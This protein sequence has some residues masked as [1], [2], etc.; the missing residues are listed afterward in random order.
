MNNLDDIGMDGARFVAYYGL[1][2]VLPGTSSRSRYA[3]GTRK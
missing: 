2:S 1:F 3:E